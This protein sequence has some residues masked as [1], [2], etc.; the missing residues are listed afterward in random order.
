V[1]LLSENINI[2]MVSVVFRRVLAAAG[3]MS[4]YLHGEAVLKGLLGGGHR[5]TFSEIT[6]LRTMSNVLNV[7]QHFDVHPGLVV[8][9]QLRSRPGSSGDGKNW[10]GKKQSK[11]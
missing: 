1:E 11:G 6:S 4:V 9:V 7:G 3:S 2:I 10:N 8:A 5:A